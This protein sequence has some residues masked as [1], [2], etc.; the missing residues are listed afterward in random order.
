[1]SQEIIDSGMYIFS[2]VM[3]N[4]TIKVESE[5]GSGEGSDKEIDG[6]GGDTGGNDSN[7]NGI[8][9][10]SP[11]WIIGMILLLLIALLLLWLI[12]FYRR[13]YEVIKPETGA[14]VVGNDKVP[15]KSE[16]VFK[17]EG[18]PVVK[19]SYRVGESG[20]W[21]IIVPGP[22]GWYVI[23]KGEITDNVTIETR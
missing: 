2:D 16:Y 5:I 4:H 17:I 10:I 23:P 18:A 19:V 1:M 9:N 21:K 11:L 20:Q 8:G 13:R 22:D 7:N 12:F 15:R 6:P 14:K 3:M